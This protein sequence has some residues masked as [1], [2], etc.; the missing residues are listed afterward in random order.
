MEPIKV[1]E[2]VEAVNGSLL[3]GDENREITFVTT[4]SKEVK[5]GTL[6]VPI[7][8]ERVDGHNYIA[9]AFELGGV[10][11]FASRHETNDLD[12][13]H[14]YIQVENTLLALQKLGAYYRNK[15]TIPVIGI[16][17]SVG[18]TT[19]KEMISAALETKKQ[20]LKTAGNMNSQVGLPLMMLRLEA[21][22]DIAVIEM[23]MSEPGEMSRLAKIA[24]PDT[25]VVTNIGVSHIGQ[26]GSQ[27]NIRSEKLNIINEFPLQNGRLY[28]NG[29]DILLCELRKDKRNQISLSQETKEKL[30]ECQLFYFG[31]ND[32]CEYYAEDIKVVGDETHFTY[33]SPSGMEEIILS[34]LGLHNVGNAMVALAIAEQYGITPAS[35][36]EGLRNYKP[37]AMRG[38]IFESNGLKII[39]DSYNAS[40]DSMKSGVQ[41]LLQMEQV[42]RRIAV[43]AD[44]LELGELSY[45]CHYDVGRY[46][47]FAGLD[48]KVIDEVVTI[49]EESKAI[50]KAIEQENKQIVAHSFCSNEEAIAYL[51]EKV[52]SGDAILV[53]GSRGMHTEE[54]V[55]ALKNHNNV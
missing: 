19:T 42:K 22:H 18:K 36:K 38:Q 52:S 26:L 5:E 44:V 37:I 2:I 47:A 7:I 1:K 23:G 45:Q 6:F 20:V 51:S 4:N 13:E 10:A 17:G 28:L 31:I 54:I 8:G 53:K 35:A 40:P 11:V 41:V 34:V 49:G 55:A 32:T 15:F 12:S 43:L 25:A 24:R 33:H 46:I 48:G 29:D 9:S 50:T 21:Q 16:T 3:Q 30:E 39:D 27:E 14:V